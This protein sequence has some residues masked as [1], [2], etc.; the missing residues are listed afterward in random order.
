MISSNAIIDLKNIQYFHGLLFTLGKKNCSN[1]AKEMNVSH[2]KMNRLLKHSAHQIKSTNWFA[3]E[4][5]KL[6]PKETSYILF[7]DTFLSKIYSKQT[8]GVDLSFDGSTG[9]PS[10]GLT[11]I[12]VIYIRDMIKNAI[13]AAPYVT[14]TMAEASYKSKTEISIEILKRLVNEISIGMFLADAHYATI[15]MLRFLNEIKLPFLM[16]F[17]KTRVVT[18]HGEKGQL[19]KIFRLRKNAHFQCVKGTYDATDCYFYAFKTSCGNTKYLISNQKMEPK[20]A[21]ETYR[22]RWNIELFH[23]TAKQYL[24]LKDCQMTDIESQLQHVRE[25][26]KA[27][28]IAEHYRKKN[29]LKTTEDAIKELRELKAMGGDHLNQ[30]VGQHL[31]A[32][33]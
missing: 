31:W 16:K 33:A 11:M 4:V 3:S 8:E 32:Y 1:L 17:P 26:M 28:T 10:M 19:T 20:V 18:I 29:N 24:G 9:K 21:V 6:V 27:Y 14:K 25:V 22:I 15:P 5:L 2:D 30:A 13:D 7:D 23:R 12:T